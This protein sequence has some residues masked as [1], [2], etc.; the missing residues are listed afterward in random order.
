MQNKKAFSLVEMIITAS[1]IILLSIVWFWAKNGYNEKTENTKVSSDI[2]TI[3]NA[4]EAFSTDN[5]SLP[6]PWWNTNFYKI[7]TT[8]S[9]SYTATWTFWTYGSITENTI[10]KKYLNVLPLDPRTNSYYSY[11]KTKNT[12]QF[13][14]AAVQT[15]DWIHIA[16]ITWNYTGIDWPYGLIR[17]YNWY[18]FVYNDSKENLPYNP[19]EL[20]LIA[21]DKDWNIYREWQTINVQAWDRLEIFFSDGSVS[22]LWDDTSV[23]VLTLNK[24][25]LCWLE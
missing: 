9:H 4:L 13:E 17:E 24:L 16:K 21:T 11:G 1:I 6:I 3:N 20:I 10:S 7:D 12:N 14:I 19:E 15:I 18:N 22:I 2:I 8:Y 23:T 25:R 5:S